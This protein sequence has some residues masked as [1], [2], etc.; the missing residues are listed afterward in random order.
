M[1]NHPL[2]TIALTCLLPC[3]PAMG[4]GSA[5]L[6]HGDADGGEVVLNGSYISAV[7]EARA[8]MA[9]HCHGRF[10]VRVGESAYLLDAPNRDQYRARFVCI[11]GNGAETGAVAKAQP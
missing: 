1:K 7:T 5:Q 4:C 6:L 8:L 9:E 2:L 11:G 10:G 3:L